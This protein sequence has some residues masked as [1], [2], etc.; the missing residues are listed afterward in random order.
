M[1][2]VVGKFASERKAGDGEKRPPR[3]RRLPRIDPVAVETATQ[4]M[5]GG[6]M[7]L[8]APAGLEFLSARKTATVDAGGWRRDVVAREILAKRT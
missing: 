4:S 1:E 5:T 2:A 3:R 6:A 8:E 7:S